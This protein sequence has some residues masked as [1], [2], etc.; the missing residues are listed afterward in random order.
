[1]KE[2]EMVRAYCRR[3]KYLFQWTPGATDLRPEPLGTVVQ[4]SCSDCY[5]DLI[6]LKRKPKR[7]VDGTYGGGHYEAAMV[8]PHFSDEERLLAATGMTP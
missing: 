2:R 7:N 4:A 8:L 6:E 5:T 1:V 3:C